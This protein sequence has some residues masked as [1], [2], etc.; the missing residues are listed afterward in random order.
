MSNNGQYAWILMA[1][2]SLQN[3]FTPNLWFFFI[4]SD[5]S[6]LLPKDSVRYHRIRLKNLNSYRVMDDWS[7]RRKCPWLH[8]LNF[9]NDLCTHF[10]EIRVPTICQFSCST[11]A[12][13]DLV[14][15]NLF[16]LFSPLN[17]R[18][19]VPYFQR[20]KIVFGNGK[21]CPLKSE[22]FLHIDLLHTK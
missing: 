22:S 9:E 4:S 14:A 2:E 5:K 19:A 17:A 18:H 1:C 7:A 11:F 20:K 8:K 21:G 10:M 15:F 6:R 12:Y 13:D 3:H 16:F